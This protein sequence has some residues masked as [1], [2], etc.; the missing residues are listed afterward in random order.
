MSENTNK[1]AAAAT[2]AKNAALVKHG[3]LNPSIVAA[4]GITNGMPAEEQYARI[5]KVVQ[6]L[7]AEE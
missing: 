4:A 1:A 5:L 6:G 2:E 3:S 7:A